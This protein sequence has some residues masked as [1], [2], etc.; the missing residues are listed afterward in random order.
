MTV[1]SQSL[2]HQVV[3]RKER[4]AAR[5]ALLMAS[6]ALVLALGCTLGLPAQARPQNP[7]SYPLM[8]PI[9]QYLIADQQTEIALAR[10]AAPAKISGAATVLV[11]GRDGYRTVA[12][13]T[14]GFTCLVERSWMSP[15]DSPQFWNPKIRGPICYNPPAVRTVLPYTITRTK[16]VCAGVS[17][18]QMHARI[19][20]TLA[21]NELPAPESGAMSY[22]MSKGGYLG[23]GVGHWYPHLMFSV[24]ATSAANWGANLD[25]SPIMYNSSFRDVPE[26]ETIFMMAVPHWSD[27]T[28]A[29]PGM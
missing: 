2:S 16:L 15:F 29:P 27:G 21:K 7:A 6:A 5:T 22:M 10:S 28:K 9:Q 12:E 4:L 19:L 25:G 8:A 11:L 20:A 26:P 3:S 18:A 1:V 24:R 14:N 17:K 23:D 13:G